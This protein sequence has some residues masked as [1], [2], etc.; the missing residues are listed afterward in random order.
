MCSD[1]SKEAK[2][3][4]VFPQKLYKRAVTLSCNSLFYEID[5][6][7]SNAPVYSW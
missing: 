2:D 1:S 3:F 4:L 5:Y 6:S 7:N